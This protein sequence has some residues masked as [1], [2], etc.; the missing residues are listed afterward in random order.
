MFIMIDLV[1]LPVPLVG[2]LDE[3]VGFED[4]MGFLVALDIDGFNSNIYT[5]LTTYA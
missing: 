3:V 2:L 4:F 5:S 1:F